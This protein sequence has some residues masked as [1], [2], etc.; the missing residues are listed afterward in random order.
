MESVLLGVSNGVLIYFILSTVFRIK[1]LNK[2]KSDLMRK[3]NIEKHSLLSLLGIN[4]HA[5]FLSTA[6]ILAWIAIVHWLEILY[7]DLSTFFLVSYYTLEAELLKVPEVVSI[8]ILF[9]VVLIV[10]SNSYLVLKVRYL[11][12]GKVITL[13]DIFSLISLVLPLWYSLEG[14]ITGV[15]FIEVA[16]AHSSITLYV[17]LTCVVIWAFMMARA[18]W[19]D[20]R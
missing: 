13:F 1:M 12:L 19:T 9:G 16:R 6:Y 8:L 20:N 15:T 10:Y 11:A 18:F 3:Y 4:T 17:G 14:L 5:F 7:N 2:V